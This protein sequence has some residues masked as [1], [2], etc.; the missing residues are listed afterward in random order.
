MGLIGNTGNAQT[1]SPHLHFGI[2][3][4]GGAVDPLPCVNP[5]VKRPTEIMVTA[6][7]LKKEFRLTSLVRNAERQYCQNTLVQPLA[8]GIGGLRVQ[9]PYGTIIEIKRSLAQPAT[10]ELQKRK[11]KETVFIYELPDTLS[12]RKLS[13]PATASVGVITY[14]DRFAF[15]RVE[16]GFEGWLRAE[17]MR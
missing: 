5:I 6:G 9:M 8:A 17:S 16:N 14:F 3:T 15:V 12:P 10:K 7:E 11:L 1:A 13:L 4:F 2:Y